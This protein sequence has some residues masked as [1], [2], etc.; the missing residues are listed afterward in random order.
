MSK[1]NTKLNEIESFIIDNE[2]IWQ[3]ICEN[4]PPLPCMDIVAT[5]INNSNHY[6]CDFTG[7]YDVF[8]IFFLGQ[9]NY[10]PAICN[11]VDENK[12]D[13]YPVY[14]INIS[15]DEQLTYVGNF[16]KYIR[17]I[18]KYC[19]DKSELETGDYSLK[20]FRQRLREAYKDSNK[21][22]KEII[23]KEYKLKKLKKIIIEKN[24]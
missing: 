14:I 1:K 13:K 6:G 19:L 15:N 4:D 16:R 9:S 21:F 24:K 20:E 12:A 17:T 10:F 11:I 5:Y 7:K 2:D 8:Q 22:S 3:I 18:L 23:F